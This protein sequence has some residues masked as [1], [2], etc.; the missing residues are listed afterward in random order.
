MLV[1]FH[2]QFYGTNYT[3][4][5]VAGQDVDANSIFIIIF[6]IFLVI[7]ALYILKCVLNYINGGKK[8]KKRK[9]KKKKGKSKKKTGYVSPY[10]FNY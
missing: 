7:F 9:S 8:S 5:L 4:N 2:I 10:K 1:R 6:R 3:T